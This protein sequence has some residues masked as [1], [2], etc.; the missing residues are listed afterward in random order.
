MLTISR[1]L[2]DGAAKS[3]YKSEYAAG[4]YYRDGERLAGVW[5]GTLASEWGL[6]GEMTQAQFDLMVDGRH[7]L[8]GEQLVSA[9][10][11]KEYEN[12]YGERI[13]TMGHRAGWDATFSAPKSVSLAALVGGDERL[14]IAHGRAV[15]EGLRELERHVEARM[16]GNRKAVWTGKFIAARF[17]H[18]M[19]RPSRETGYAAPQLH[20]HVVVFNMT[21]LEDGRIKPLQPKELFRAQADATRSYRA[22][23][24]RELVGLGYGLEW[25]ERTGAPEIKGFSRDYL[26]ANSPRSREVKKNAALMKERLEAIGARVIEGAGLNQAAARTRRGG[27]GF[28]REEMKA[29]QREVDREYGGQAA[30]VVEEALARVNKEQGQEQS[31]TISPFRQKLTEA[32]WEVRDYLEQRL[33]PVKQLEHRFGMYNQ[34][35]REKD[36]PTRDEVKPVK[37]V[38]D[39]V[40]RADEPPQVKVD[41][42][43]GI[44]W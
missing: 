13:K 3:Y 35:A 44:S 31:R 24:G 7:P 20:T 29:W 1:P 41:Q 12:K 6:Q 42:Q 23:L 28:D 2:S 11:V 39:A 27:K 34:R 19:A 26:L 22:S 25:D 15:S 5:E 38:S 32:A 21:K 33:D 30:R 9:A 4:L 43:G 37:V 16:G 14:I 8:T 36:A 10:P 18:D 17:E 40:K